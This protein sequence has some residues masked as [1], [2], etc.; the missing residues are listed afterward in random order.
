MDMLPSYGDHPSFLRSRLYKALDSTPCL[1]P[2]FNA[3][4]SLFHAEV[5]AQP[6]QES[7]VLGLSVSDVQASRLS[8][9]AFQSTLDM[10]RSTRARP[11]KEG[12]HVVR[13]SSPSLYLLLAGAERLHM[14]ISPA[15]VRPVSPPVHA[16]VILNS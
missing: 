3:I 6:L 7:W 12:T 11:H 5:T 1:H 15:Y 16:D 2:S 14:P 4:S 9:P 13:E 8:C 10:D